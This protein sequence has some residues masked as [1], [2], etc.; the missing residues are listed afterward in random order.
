MATCPACSTENVDAARFC[1]ACGASLVAPEPAREARKVV[2]VV[3]ADITGSTGL[4]EHLDPEALR[5]IMGRW[6]DAMSAVLERHGGSV[7]KFIGDAVVAV[8]GVPVVHE[9]D[10]LRAVRAATEMQAALATL[11]A[12]LRTER[13]LEIGMRVGVNTGPVVVG[14][15]R[16]GGSRATGDAVNVAARLQHAAEPGETLV[17][18]STWRLVREAVTTG[19]PRQVQVKGRDEA[20][21]V[22][23]LV[24]VDQTAQAI[25]RRVGGTMVGRDRELGIIR[26]AFDRSVVEERCV[27]VTV[28]GSA[29][30]GKSRLVHEF[31][32][33]ARRTRPSCAA[34]AC[35][36][37]RASPGIRWPRSCD[38]R[39][40]S[41]KRPSRWRSWTGCAIVSPGSTTPRRS[42]P[43]WPSRSGS[44]PN[45]RRSKSSSGRSDAC[46]SISRRIARRS[47]SWTT[48]S[49]PSRRSS[50]SSSIWPIGSTASRCSCWRWRVP[51]LL[52]FRVGWGGG[53]P[54]ATTFLL[55]PLPSADTEQLV[56][57]L[58][59]GAAVTPLARQRIAAAADGNPL[60][61]EQVIEMLL[62]D[63]LVERGPN[64][65][66]VVGDLETISVPPTIQAL[67]AARLD[68]LSDGERRTI[69][70]A[71]VVGKEFGQRDVSEST[72]TAGRADVATQLM[73]LVRKEL[74]RP[75]RRR[76]GGGEAYRFRH[77]LI[78]DA[79]YDSLPKL[80]RAELHEQFADWLERTAGDR[81]AELDEITGYHLDQARTYRL[82]L[83][84]DDERTRTLARRAG[85]RLAAAGRRTADRGE[86]RTAVRLMTQAEA[87]LADD[88]AARFSVLLELLLIGIELHTPT[89]MEVAKRA[90]AVA[91]ELGDLAQR[92]ARL[93]VSSVR[94][95]MDPSFQISEIR[96]EAESAARA[97]EEAGDLDAT[98]DAYLVLLLI[99]LNVAHWREVASWA[100]LG[101]ERASASGRDR[102]GEEFANW[103]AAAQVWGSSDA[104]ASLG[105]IEA[106]LP[107]TSR[108]L[109]RSSLMESMSVLHAVIG[110]GPSAEAV[111][112]EATRITDDLGHPRSEFRHAYARYALDDFPA[113]LRLARE[114]SAELE[115]RGETGLRSTMAGLEAWILALTGEDDDAMSA[116]DRSRRLGAEDD[117]VTQILWRA[118][119]SLVLARRGKRDEAD[120]VSADGIR[121]AD[122]T[123]L[124]DAG[125]AWL[126][127]AHV[128][129]SQ[130][131]GAEAT[132]AARRSVELYAAK[133]FVNGIRRA[134]ALL[135][136]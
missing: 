7:E 82:D 54:D 96:T 32:A 18:E 78:R 30:V 103:L 109:T 120:R 130:G 115:R 132:D 65:A 111:H 134:E 35:R 24:A 66:V 15:A 112:L 135:A 80:E 42:L 98:L 94:T 56:E 70:R 92:Q 124:W 116:A 39:S 79:A 97:F 106:M 11:N 67:L 74:I 41:M 73:G 114:E 57:E 108:R 77:L 50:T 91:A 52:D 86:I 84:P 10:A 60:Y 23:R 104:S 27:L 64:G 43:S 22:R 12:G 59:E 107:S 33:A 17:G 93:W 20:V 85:L 68:R 61:V 75:D 46:S 26:A 6:F 88:P 117:A 123:D 72:P 81:L 13:G 29:G 34:A 16:A 62:D 125:T 122:D 131:R 8:F 49:G 3:F 37:A 51:E 100:R 21:T 45:R 31:L 129:S 119:T 14:D 101:L 4:G 113:A 90:Q 36:T 71:A 25:H 55:E 53:K 127:R 128:L 58:L 9:D 40:A 87:L 133:G 126:A 83:G 38:R 102:R 5:S 105:V 89:S 1:M 47:S 63:G 99:D 28:L 19:E 44:H 110:D 118:A 2:T 69:E 48:F 136:G 76:D 121:I 95:M